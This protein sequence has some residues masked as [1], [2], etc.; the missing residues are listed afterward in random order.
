MKKVLAVIGTRPEAI[1]MAPVIKILR[2]RQRT[3][4]IRVC[5][6]G[7]HR[8]L[9]DQVI[10]YLPILVDYDLDIMRKG[11][12]L[13]QLT[14]IILNSF[15]RVLEDFE[16]QIILIQGDTTTALVGALTG[17]YNR[18]KVGHVEAGLR[19]LH[20]YAPFPEE[21]NRRLIGVLADYHFAPTERAKQ[22]LLCEGID[23][24]TVLVTGNT[25]IDALFLTIEKIRHSPPPIGEIESVITSDRKIVL[26]TGHR[27]ENFG[28]GFRNI[29]EAIQLLARKFPG[30]A[31][32]YPVHLNPNVQKPVFEFL[33][34]LDN[35]HLIPP[36]VY[37]AFV[38]LMNLAYIIITDSGGIQEEAPSL[39]KPVLVM[40]NVT[41]RPEAI[42]AG[43]TRLVGVDK[44]SIVN[45]VSRLL[46]DP[47]IRNAMSHRGN[48]YGDGTAAVKIADYLE[49]VLD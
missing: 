7:Q 41:E 42:E 13:S 39:G 40:R 27:R 48:P 47:G 38:R 26:I 8:E 36:L 37:P 5:V 25:V 43:T 10:Q 28:E 34:N 1:K 46:V 9:L 22:S 32:I 17:Y 2:E 29:C 19:T 23:E 21:I 18:I 31:F 20:K 30:I 24:K 44:E 16:P 12:N 11:Q 4:E 33:G 3:F 45:E 14:A 15:H 6:T 35:V 49:N